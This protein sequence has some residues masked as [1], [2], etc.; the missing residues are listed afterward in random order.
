[1]EPMSR[2]HEFR[3]WQVDGELDLVPILKLCLL[4]G[5]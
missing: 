5:I 2:V 1:M 4:A 3:N